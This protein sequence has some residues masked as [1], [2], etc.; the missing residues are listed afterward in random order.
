MRARAVSVMRC[1]GCLA[2]RACLG[3]TGRNTTAPPM[4][5]A[6]AWSMISGNGDGGGEYHRHVDGLGRSSTRSKIRLVRRGAS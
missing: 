4:P 2:F 6:A 3:E 1:W 5:R